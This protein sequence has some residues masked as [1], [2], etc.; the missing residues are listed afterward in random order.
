MKQ[1]VVFHKDLSHNKAEDSISQMLK[2]L[3]VR[4]G[5]FWVIFKDM[6]WPG[7]VTPVGKYLALNVP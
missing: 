2:F 4:A 5:V 1:W 7:I 3:I 6:V